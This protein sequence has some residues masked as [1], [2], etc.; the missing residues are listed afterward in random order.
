MGA[1][2][3]PLTKGN[4][5]TIAR[6]SNVTDVKP[7]YEREGEYAPYIFPYSKI[8][9]WNEDNFGPLWIPA[10]GKTVKIDTS[11]ICLY[12]RIIDVYENNDLRVEGRQ[13]IYK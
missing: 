3:L 1:Y 8:L 9:K 11:N 4:A 10:K 2:V 6:F 5:E 7:I 12:E 13:N